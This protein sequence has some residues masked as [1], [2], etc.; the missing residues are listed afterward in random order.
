M[1]FFIKILCQTH[2]QNRI[3]T[4]CDI[5]KIINSSK[6]DLYIIQVKYKNIVHLL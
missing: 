2:N 6:P 1:F 3:M 5:S 4:V